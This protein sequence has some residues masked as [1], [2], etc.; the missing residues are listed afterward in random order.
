MCRLKRWMSSHVV[1]RIFPCQLSDLHSFIKQNLHSLSFQ[2]KSQNKTAIVL[3]NYLCKISV[4]DF[5]LV[6]TWS[7]LLL[8]VTSH[9]ESVNS[10]SIKTPHS[11]FHGSVY[12]SVNSVRSA[13][14]RWSQFGHIHSSELSGGILHRACG[15]GDV[16]NELIK[17]LASGNLLLFCRRC[18]RAV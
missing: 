5:L 4:T 14:F 6:S 17:L 10:K 8:S 2:K 11:I 9:D 13:H 7:E 18:V 1:A 3:K 15:L 16:C 12:H